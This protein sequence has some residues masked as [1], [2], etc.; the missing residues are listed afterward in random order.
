MPK[1]TLV[2]LYAHGL[3]VID[4]AR[5]ELDSGFTVL[6][7][8]TG[9][10]KTLLLGALNLCLGDEGLGSRHAITSDMRAAAVFS[11]DGAS[12]TVL[13]REAT[14]TGRLRS[15]VN[16]V[17]SSAE[18]LRLLASDLVVI[19]GQHDS[20]ALRNRGE[21]LHI[22]D[23]SASISTTGLDA[24]RTKLRDAM[25]LRESLG[26]NGAVRERE[27]D[28][29]GFQI[30][31]LES[32]SLTSS[33]ELDDVLV[34]LTTITQLRDG[35]TALVEALEALDN[36]SDQAVLTQFARAIDHIPTSD[37]YGPARE[38]LR[39]SLEQAR[40]GVHELVNLTNS[41]A[42]DPTVLQELEDR[43]TFLRQIARKYGGS[44]ETALR[45]LV[46]LRDQLQFHHDAASRLVTLDDEI[47]E[48]EMAVEELAREALQLRSAAAASLTAAVLVQLPRV[49][50]AN[51]SLRFVVDGDDG[52]QAQILFSPNPGQPEGPLQAL[53]SGGELSRVLLALSLETVHEDVVA[54]CDEV[55]AGVGGQ[56]AQQ[57]GECLAELGERQQVLAVTHLASVAAKADHHFVVEKIVRDGISRTTLR[58]VTGDDRIGEIARMLAGDNYAT[59]SRALAR[60]LLETH[61]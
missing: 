57:I 7:G 33:R 2:E 25:A 49:A 32:A 3:G 58:T 17:P 45:A 19:H 21:V 20:L 34:D 12:D 37:I 13:V 1:A 39:G 50:L 31:E 46:D 52:A 48:L 6:T 42:F 36:D 28:F 8:E 11:R 26:G 14:S 5:M 16:G 18:T 24:A 61:R 4:D 44:L 60:R 55:D 40:D 47:V 9:A 23:R 30:G 38:L 29:I 15:A 27:L 51:A 43:A 41:D 35:Q 54:V 10:G 22:I 59:D 53:A 56:V